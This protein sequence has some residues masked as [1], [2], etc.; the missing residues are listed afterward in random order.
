MRECGMSGGGESGGAGPHRDF[1]ALPLHW[2][3]GKV[4]Q[5]Q[6]SCFISRT[7][8]SNCKTTGVQINKES[9]FT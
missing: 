6:Q 2:E 9:I 3:Q 8:E 1:K 5:G 4:V 7:S